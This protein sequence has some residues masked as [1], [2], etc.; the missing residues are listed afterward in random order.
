MPELAYVNGHFG[1]I[2]TATVSI[3]DRGFQFADGVYEVFAAFGP[4]VFRQADHFDRLRRSLSLIDMNVDLESLGLQSMI[5]DGIEQAGFD[6]TMVYLQVTRGTQPRSHVYDDSVSPTVVAT[7][8]RL[9]EIDPQVRARGVSVVT[10]EDTR[11]SCC[12]IKSVALLPNILAKNRA[13]RDGYDDAIFVS[14][15]GEVREGTS[16]NVFVVRGGILHTPATSPTI[17]HGVT[18]RYI[19]ECAHNV[20]VTVAEGPVSVEEFATCDEAFLS[21]TVLDVLAIT[22]LNGQPIGDGAVGPV[23]RRLHGAF[24]DGLPVRSSKRST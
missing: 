11:W 22:R 6:R 7:F 12:E 8:K 20:G 2:S 24:L 21:S 1:P 19:L 13:K 4:H 3:E 16:S 14:P 15:S 18:R 10:V 23:T 17:L 5:R 9:P